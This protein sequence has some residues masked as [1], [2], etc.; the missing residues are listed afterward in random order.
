MNSV[1]PSASSSNSTG[2]A[3]IS[4]ATIATTVDQ[5]DRVN[6]ELPVLLVASSPTGP[7][8]AITASTTARH[9]LSPATATTVAA[10]FEPPLPSNKRPKRSPQEDAPGGPTFTTVPSSSGEAHTTTTDTTSRDYYFD[11]YAHHAI[12]EEMLKDT[13]RTQAYRNAILQNKHLFENKIVLDVGCGTGILSMFAVQAGAKHVYAVDSSAIAVQ[14]QQIVERNHFQDKI[15]VIRGKVEEIELP[16]TTPHVDVILSEWMGY[17]LLYESMLESVLFARDKWLRPST[18]IVFPDKAVMYIAAIEDG[19]V[20]HDRLDYWENV[21]GFDMTPIQEI[22]YQEPVV[23]TI[24]PKAI[25]TDCVPI[26]KLD[27]LTCKKE[28]LSF[29][30]TFR[31]E[32]QRNDFVHGLV[33]YFECAFTQETHKPIAFSTAPFCPY[34]HWKQ[35]ILYLQ[36]HELK[37][38]AGERLE[39]KLRMTPN[40]RNNRDLDIRVVLNFRGKYEKLENETFEYRLR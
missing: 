13:V 30:S 10:S 24:D 9:S 7:T 21:Y 1:S 29:E 27:I 15:T 28:D 3:P 12:H 14:A 33:T 39:G 6:D 36:R 31:L 23:D 19:Q 17:S 11:S 40:A 20:K 37:V 22:A 35:T 38:C 16:S 25:V 8:P 4:T 2:T 18:G 34:T 5:N 26:L 32:M